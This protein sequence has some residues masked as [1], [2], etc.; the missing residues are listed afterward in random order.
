MQKLLVFFTNS[1]YQ[2]INFGSNQFVPSAGIAIVFAELLTTVSPLSFLAVPVQWNFTMA[3]QAQPLGLQKTSS[4]G[5]FSGFLIW[6]L[7]TPCWPL[8]HGQSSPYSSVA[9]T[10]NQATTTRTRLGLQQLRVCFFM[11]LTHKSSFYAFCAIFR[12]ILVWYMSN[13]VHFQDNLM[14]LSW[15]EENK[16][17]QIVSN[18]QF[19]NGGKF[20]GHISLEKLSLGEKLQQWQKVDKLVSFRPK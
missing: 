14:C 7:F 13:F 12:P 11:L 16:H 18:S 1:R 3:F 9:A 4:F 2:K 6:W 8:P 17:V 5:N 15:L 20:W 19:G 10:L